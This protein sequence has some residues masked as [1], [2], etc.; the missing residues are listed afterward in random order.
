MPAT[1]GDHSNARARY[2]EALAIARRLGD[3]YHERTWVANLGRVASDLG[4]YPEAQARYR[5]ALAIARQLGKQDCALLE[6]C[7]ELL[8]RL[9]RCTDATVL[10]GAAEHLA[11]RSEQ[12]RVASNQGR[13]D[14]TLSTCR[15]RLAR[16]PCVGV[17]TWPCPRMGASG[18]HGPG[19]AGLSA[20]ARVIQPTGSVSSPW[21]ASRL[22]AVTPREP[23]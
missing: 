16:A 23:G 15:D 3:R 9:D 2:G 6:A 13:Y 11:A 17:R 21:Q 12:V 5:D 22:H 8:A 18:G 7:A 19:D 20:L 10:L 1:T 4:D 14:A